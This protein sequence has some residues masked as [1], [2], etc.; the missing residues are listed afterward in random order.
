[1]QIL[2]QAVKSLSPETLF[3]VN[4][5]QVKAPRLSKRLLEGL[6]SQALQ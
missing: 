2:T 4:R 6:S 1:M 5:P 3:L